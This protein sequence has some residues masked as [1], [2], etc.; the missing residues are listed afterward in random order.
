MKLTQNR[1]ICK[2]F[3]KTLN[4]SS[5][6]CLRLEQCKRR[7]SATL[8]GLEKFSKVLTEYFLAR[9]P[10]DTGENGQ[11]FANVVELAASG[12]TCEVFE[13]LYKDALDRVGRLAQLQKDWGARSEEELWQILMSLHDPNIPFLLSKSRRAAA[14]RAQLLIS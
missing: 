10:A 9:I 5:V 2:T 4:M 11:H 1:N 7:I 8:V 13:R 14:G 6:D 3:K 12:T